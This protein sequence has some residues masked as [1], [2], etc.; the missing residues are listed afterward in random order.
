[1][2]KQLFIK[3]LI[4]SIYSAIIMIVSLRV[5]VKIFLVLIVIEAGFLIF[6]QLTSLN[7]NTSFQAY[8]SQVVEICSGESYR[9]DCYDREIP[10][11]LDKVS[12]EE[13]FLIT[14]LVQEQDDEYWYCHV[15]GHNVSARE[16]AKDSEKWQEVVARCPT[17]VCSNGCI[18]GAFQ[19]RFRTDALPDSEIA[20]LKPELEDIC[21]KRDGWNPTR[22]EQATCYH[23][24]GHLTMYV[25]SGNIEKSA[26][27][28]EVTTKKQDGR[29]YSQL[30]FDGVFMQIFQPLEPEDFAIVE[31][32]APAKQ[33]LGAFCS[34]FSLKQQNSCWSEGWPLYYEEIITPEGLVEF[35]SVPKEPSAKDRCYLALFY[36]VAAQF[37]LNHERMVSF[38]SNIKEQ[39]RAQ[40][41]ANMASRII[42]TDT[43]LGERAVALC[44]EAHT[45]SVGEQCYEELLFYS[46]YNFHSGSQDFYNLC[47]SL[48][49]PWG[50]RCLAERTLI[51]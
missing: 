51:R 6:L 14:K 11:L 47:N 19:E 37:R 16:T 33:E 34:K 25:T 36:V 31:G 21:E 18:H 10:K 3:T 35:C 26:A 17:G 42:G 49:A 38:C 15:L 27:L 7:Q 48:P 40:C 46:T 30:C 8:A 45:L 29:N 23:A 1:M 41:F 20:E 9:P 50:E 24:L 28:C 22:L 5:V 2:G 39:R 12:L 4:G 13:V 43:S 44:R 32:L